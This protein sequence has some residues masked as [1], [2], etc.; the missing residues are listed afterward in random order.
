MRTKEIGVCG[1]SDVVDAVRRQSSSVIVFGD[2]ELMAQV[3]GSD[4]GAVVI[5]ASVRD[6]GRRLQ[7]ADAIR[8]QL[9]GTVVVLPANGPLQ[10]VV[11]RHLAVVRRASEELDA[12]GLQTA[13]HAAEAT[14][15]TLQRALA[16]LP[17]DAPTTVSLRPDHPALA[18]TVVQLDPPRLE[19]PAEPP[20]DTFAIDIVVDTDDVVLAQ[21]V[22]E[23]S[24][25][26]AEVWPDTVTERLE[27][28]DR[29]RARRRASTVWF[30]MGTGVTGASSLFAPLG[31]VDPPRA[32]GAR[33]HPQP[34]PRPAQLAR[35]PA[36][37]A[38]PGRADV[39][40]IRVL[41]ACIGLLAVCIGMALFWIF[42]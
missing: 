32:A 35:Q 30:S 26:W 22:S 19:S 29:I 33:P 8:D 42:R 1:P 5:D 17:D 25:V 16:P 40:T 11:R 38:K 13:L 4:V 23:V 31:H 18:D 9:F 12:D 37:V 6:S 10:E 41:L 27:R 3:E 14:T 7:L 20:P 24:G 28:D 39:H 15:V 34:R 2:D 36:P 21:E